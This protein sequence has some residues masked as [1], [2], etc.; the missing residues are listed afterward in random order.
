[1]LPVVNVTWDD[2]SAFCRW[3]SAATSRPFRLPTEAEWEKAARGPKGLRYP[4]GDAWEPAALN[5][6]NTLGALTP[7]DRYS[8]DSDS[9]YGAAD[10]LGNVWEWCSDWF[11][12]QIYGRRATRGSSDP[13]GPPTGQGYVVR[14]GAFDSPPRHTRSAHRNWYYPDTARATL[15]FRL[16]AGAG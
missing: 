8:P 12:P 10:L 9:P 2:A 6:D 4:W 5:S 15:G 14:G 11:D 7:V 16:A 1:M 13:I 3:L